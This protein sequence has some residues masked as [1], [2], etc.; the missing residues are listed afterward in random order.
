MS[1]TATS[2][3]GNTF[4]RI[5]VYDMG[6]GGRNNLLPGSSEEGRKMK[7][8]FHQKAK[9]TNG[10]TKVRCKLDGSIHNSCDGCPHMKPTIMSRIL[11]WIED[12]EERA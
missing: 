10:K 4:G 7:C 6:P 9:L 3:D 11:K 2:P 12:R 8:I 5:V 1:N